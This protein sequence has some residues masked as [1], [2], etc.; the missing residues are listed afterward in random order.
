MKRTDLTSCFA[1]GLVV[2]LA[3]LLKCV[4]PHAIGICPHLCSWPTV[5]GVVYAKRVYL[6]FR[7]RRYFHLRMCTVLTGVHG[8]RH[9]EIYNPCCYSGLRQPRECVKFGQWY[10]SKKVPLG[11]KSIHWIQTSDT[12]YIYTD[13]KRLH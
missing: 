13:S 1:Q 3:G 2:Y 9:T 10:L 11:F 12:L 4:A 8:S 5:R 7:G 6:W